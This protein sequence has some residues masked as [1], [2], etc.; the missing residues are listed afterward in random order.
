[1]A[2]FPAVELVIMTLVTTGGTVELLMRDRLQDNDL[3]TASITAD[4][5]EFVC[6]LTPMSGAMATT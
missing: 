4:V 6:S 2:F 1:M 5:P 3:L